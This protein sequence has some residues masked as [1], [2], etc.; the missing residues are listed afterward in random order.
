MP[1]LNS[2]AIVDEFSSSINEDVAAL[3][4][5]I[6][7]LIRQ[8]VLESVRLRAEMPRSDMSERWYGVLLSGTSVIEPSELT[9]SEDDTAL[10]SSVVAEKMLSEAAKELFDAYD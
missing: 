5:E 9:Q 4:A 3:Q 10:L 2:K 1:A 8:N 6:A 7:K